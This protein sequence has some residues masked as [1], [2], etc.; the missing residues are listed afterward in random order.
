M[1]RNPFFSRKILFFTALAEYSAKL[2]EE[3]VDFI[4]PLCHLY[5]FQ[6]NTTAERF[7]FPVILSGCVNYPR[8]RSCVAARAR[9][10]V[11]RGLFFQV[12]FATHPR[13]RAVALTAVRVLP[14]NPCERAL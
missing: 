14:L 2:T 12:V 8:S 6:D 11:I 9:S 7:D 10:A 5:E 13:A 4:L 1:P 3:G